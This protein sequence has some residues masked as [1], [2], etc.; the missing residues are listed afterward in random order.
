MNEIRGGLVTLH[1]GKRVAWDYPPELAHLFSGFI[2][3]F[4][5]PRPPDRFLAVGIRDQEDSFEIENSSCFFR[6]VPSEL[7]FINV[8]S[9]WTRR[10]LA[11][12]L[13]SALVIHASAVQARQGAILMMGPKGSGKS[14][15]AKALCDEGYAFLAEDGAPVGLDDGVVFPSMPMSFLP[16][17]VAMPTKL[18]RIISIRYVPGSRTALQG[19]KGPAAALELL[20]ENFNLRATGGR[21]LAFIARISERGLF[22]LTFPDKSEGLRVVRE[23]AELETVP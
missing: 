20:R 16:E 8:L 6:E 14:T 7:D 13:A 1:F 12:E 18:F 21:G 15:L 22:S 2:S 19:M 10:M 23:I 4:R 5:D 11:K 3:R 17:N 9:Y